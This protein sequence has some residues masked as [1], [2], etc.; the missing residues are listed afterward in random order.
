MTQ[1]NPW[2]IEA[3]INWHVRKKSVWNYCYCYP[4][5]GIAMRYTNFDLPGLLGSAFGVYPF[6]EPYIRP[7]KSLSF[8]IRF[9]LGPAY[10][11]H[12]YDEVTNPDNLFFSSHISFI[13]VFSL[14]SNY[15]FSDRLNF[16]LAANFNHISNAGYSEPNLGINYP[17]LNAGFDYSFDQPEF[18]QREKDPEIVL[19]DKKNRFD[20]VGSFSAKPV[21]TGT[22]Q[23]RAPV[24]GLST[25]YSRAV[26]RIF[27][28]SGGFEWVNALSLRE[29]I[30]ND[31]IIDESGEHLDHNKVGMLAGI[32]WLFGRFIFYQQFGY[33]LYA[34]YIDEA[35]LYQRYGLTLRLTDHIFTGLNVKAYDQDADY[36]DIRIGINL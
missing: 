17:S 8:A 2:C 7:E 34:P 13:G 26:G 19:V 22:S 3:D 35:R 11:T 14:S 5:S 36:M 15:A 12:V 27:A 24:Y 20:L 1:S 10:V 6:I 4:R 33:Y 25:N 29:K 9:G 30:I 21:K 31:N 18:L 16:R 28:L 23:N 32:E